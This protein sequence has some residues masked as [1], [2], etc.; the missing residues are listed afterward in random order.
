MPRMWLDENEASLSVSKFFFFFDRSILHTTLECMLNSALKQHKGSQS[1]YA[2]SWHQKSCACIITCKVKFM[3]LHLLYT[4]RSLLTNG[5]LARLWVCHLFSGVH[6]EMTR[7]LRWLEAQPKCIVQY[8]CSYLDTVHQHAGQGDKNVKILIPDSTI[9]LNG[10]E[11]NNEITRAPHSS[12]P[13][14]N[15][16]QNLKGNTASI[17]RQHGMQRQ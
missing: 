2:H 9:P 6:Q 3:D 11:R 1:P 12:K 14:W 16:V 8:N 15:T 10:C 7:M 4:L 17:I 13:W 5:E